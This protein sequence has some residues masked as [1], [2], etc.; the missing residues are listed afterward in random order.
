MNPHEQLILPY[1]SLL[2]ASGL[3]QLG[4][5][6]ICVCYVQSGI[7]GIPL[8]WHSRQQFR[9]RGLVPAH[10]LSADG[11]Y[12]SHVSTIPN[13]RLI[14]RD[15]YRFSGNLNACQRQI[16]QRREGSVE[17]ILSPV[18]KGGQGSRNE[19]WSKLVLHILFEKKRS[20]R[21]LYLR[22]RLYQS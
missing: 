20:R 8:Y 11:L 15:I 17:Q 12:N 21:N 18:Y 2:A 3:S 19:P 13:I 9:F 1:G 4:W 6:G 5:S 16:C 22:S 14:H 7:W 10:L